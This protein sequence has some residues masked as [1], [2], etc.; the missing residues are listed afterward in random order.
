M[1]LKLPHHGSSQRFKEYLK[2]EDEASR[3]KDKCKVRD[4]GKVEVAAR[5]GA[6]LKIDRA[7]SGKGVSSCVGGTRSITPEHRAPCDFLAT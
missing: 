5:L 3:S 4:G 6:S 1:V 2:I 7:V